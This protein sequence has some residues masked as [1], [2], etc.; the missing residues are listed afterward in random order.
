L[1]RDDEIGRGSG[2]E[3][4]EAAAQGEWPRYRAPQRLRFRSAKSARRLRL[5]GR[6]GGAFNAE[7][8]VPI[9]QQFRERHLVRLPLG[10]LTKRGYPKFVAAVYKMY[11]PIFSKV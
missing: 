7:W 11:V 3:N 2:D 9:Q 8:A 1:R 6:L 4:Q 10:T 5:G